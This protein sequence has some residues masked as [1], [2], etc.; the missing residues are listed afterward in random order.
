MAEI[1]QKHGVNHLCTYIQHL[2]SQGSVYWAYYAEPGTLF[3]TPYIHDTESANIA[4]RNQPQRG[5]GCNL[6]YNGAFSEHDSQSLPICANKNIPVTQP[7][8]GKRRVESTNTQQFV[9][10]LMAYV[11]YKIHKV[12]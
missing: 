10:K 1:R 11:E 3:A 7:F 5:K 2:I 8:G 4:S 12:I 9:R 6:S